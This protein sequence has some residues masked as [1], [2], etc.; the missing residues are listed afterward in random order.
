MK[1]SV[2]GTKFGKMVEYAKFESGRIEDGSPQND[3]L[4]ISAREVARLPNTPSFS[5]NKSR[6][7]WL[8]GGMFPNCQSH[9]RSPLL[10]IRG[11]EADYSKEG[12]LTKRE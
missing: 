2:I 1:T 11:G 3:S 10:T 4:H 9:S 7:S 12:K 8:L 5:T 6:I